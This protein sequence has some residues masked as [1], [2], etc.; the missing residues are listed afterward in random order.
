MTDHDPL[1]R[2]ELVAAYLDGEATPAE[3]AAVEADPNLL[4][5]AT[6]KR[7]V[8]D[9]VAA[10]VL[11][12]PSDVKRAHIA[13]ALAVSSTAPNVRAFATKRRR[14]DL[15]KVASIAAAV[16]A[17]LAVPIILLSSG[18]SND[19]NAA[20]ATAEF[21]PSEE[22][23]Q[24]A[25]A[26]D[27]LGSSDS[28]A[29]P[30]SSSDEA[31]PEPANEP[32]A[33]P[34]A[35][36]ADEPADDNLP[37]ELLQ[38]EDTRRLDL[39]EL[40]T[41]DEL[42]FGVLDNPGGDTEGELFGVLGASLDPQFECVLSWL[43]DNPDEVGSTISTGTAILDGTNVTF[44]A[45]NPFADIEQQRVVVLNEACGLVADIIVN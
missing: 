23:P 34:A 6:L 18:R 45:F 7:Q 1:D 28:A 10:P 14:M 22:G 42:V 35:E 26:D 25:S 12:P 13:A 8:A 3:R 37:A 39:G 31:A 40:A 33:E 27:A 30:G 19:D 15:T 11:A 9:M 5:R 36:A 16:I 24:V 2:D 17:V 41:E 43:E 29:D 32:A 44:I 20:T 4:D 38:L 21:A